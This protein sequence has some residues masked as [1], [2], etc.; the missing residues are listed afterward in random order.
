MLKYIYIKM[1]TEVHIERP[2]MGS[3]VRQSSK[4]QMFS[5]TDLIKIANI[6]RKEI[7]L[8]AFNFQQFLN[9]KGTKEFIE[10]LQKTNERVIMTTRGAQGGT[11]V[12]PLLFIDIALALNPKFKV[13]VY[14]WLYDELVKSRN[15][16][17][18]S[19]RKMCG[20][21]YEATTNKT[22]FHKS[23][24]KVAN[25]IKKKLNVEDWNKASEEQLKLRDKI[26][27]NIALLAGVLRNPN[28]AVRIGIIKALE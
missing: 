1:K 27:E 3:I 23:I 20:A 8:S 6:K 7:G 21:L 2:F 10:E 14:Q 26:H 11:W 9:L 19:Y 17:G 28:E 13:E 4:T 15:N 22:T 12:H 24:S 16:S 18:E 25:I 5:A